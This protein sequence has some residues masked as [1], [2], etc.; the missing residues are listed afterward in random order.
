MSEGAA[1]F[2]AKFS[3]SRETLDRLRIYAD[4]LVKWNRRI[5]LVAPK[6]IPDLWQR[7]FM[8]SAQIH[9]FKPEEAKTW[10]DLGSGG[11]FP[12]I[13]VAVLESAT[14]DPTPVTLIESDQRKSTFLRTVIRETSVDAKVLA[15]RIDEVPPQKA[16]VLTARA[17][18]PLDQLLG[19][20]SFHMA[21][22]G[23]AIFPK[24]AN[25]G[26]EVELARKTWSFKCESLPSM[27]DK[28]AAILKISE[29]TR[30]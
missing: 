21:P 27:T 18:A 30:V 3:V 9:A 28:S 16:D 1:E 22:G 5:N 7:H 11:G 12:G 20:A 25:A 8:D 13:I 29:I 4:L 26:S 10:V 24:G 6:S 2:A 17:L 23:L 15:R 19:F 14:D